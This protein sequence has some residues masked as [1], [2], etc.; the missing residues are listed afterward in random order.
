VKLLQRL[1]IWRE[2][3]RLEAKAR[4]VPSPTTYVDLG[5][6]YVNLGMPDQ[7]LR[8]SEDGLTLFPQSV[9]LRRLHNFAKRSHLRG[10]IT[11]LRTQINR[12]PKPEYYRDLAGLYLELGDNAAVQGTC[13]EGIRRF[14][15]EPEIFLVLGR[16]RLAAFYR[17][18]RAK[19]GLEAVRCL[20]KVVSLERG[21]GSA[22]KL[23]AEVTLRVGA[24]THAL[25]HLKLLRDLDPRDEEVRGMC[26]S[27]EKQTRDFPGAAEVDLD[28]LFHQIETARRL[29]SGPIV[30]DLPVEHS[31]TDSAHGV[32]N[33]VREALTRIADVPGVTKAAY[34]RGSKALIKGD[35][36]DGNDPF[37]RMSRGMAKASQRTCRRMD[38]G[39]FSKGVLDGG[40]GHVCICCYGIVVAAV[41]C[42]PDSPIDRILAELQ[43]LVAG[44]LYAQEAAR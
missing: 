27:A 7:T 11:N 16:A 28:Q 33:F 25:Q 40:F 30:G 19:D 36:R 14:P 39:S 17:D 8:V 31:P 10:R 9:E 37:L 38:V 44:S 35:I 12:S 32:A 13:E 6:V 23:L 24:P 15:A 1:K 29:S 34:I 18:L 22:H 43:D 2:L 5:Q 41:L 4:E 20:R 3:K 42:E 26:A 21:N